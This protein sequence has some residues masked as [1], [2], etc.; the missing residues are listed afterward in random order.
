MNRAKA[1]SFSAAAPESIDLAAIG[2]AFS[3]MFGA[4]AATS[5]AAAF[6]STTSRRGDFSP[7]N[8]A[9]MISAFSLASPPAISCSVARRHP[10]FFRLDFVGSHRV[11]SRASAMRVFPVIVISSRPSSPCT[12]SARRSPSMLSASASFS[13]RSSE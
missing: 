11:P 6:S 13:T 5:A 1:S 7:L 3:K 10:E 12:T 4:A 8:T 9:R 2:I